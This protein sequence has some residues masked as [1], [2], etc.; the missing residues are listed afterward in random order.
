MLKRL[1]IFLHLSRL[2]G[3]IVKQRGTGIQK[4]SSSNQEWKVSSSKG[5]GFLLGALSHCSAMVAA[6][7][8][9]G[10]TRRGAKPASASRLV[11]IVLTFICFKTKEAS[12]RCG[13]PIY[14]DKPGDCQATARWS[15]DRMPVVS[16]APATA[17]WSNDRMPVVS[18]AP[19]TARWSNDRMPVV[20]TFASSSKPRHSKGSWQIAVIPMDL[21]SSTFAL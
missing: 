13:L 18:P 6:S 12:H 20:S 9:A 5:P 10:L 2:T 8:G 17:R 21:G 1:N 14:I 15:N 7:R 4:N 19:A 3:L 16:P 11:G